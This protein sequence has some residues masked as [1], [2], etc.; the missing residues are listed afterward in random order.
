MNEIPKTLKYSQGIQNKQGY[1]VCFIG[2]IAC[3]KSTL[4]NELFNKN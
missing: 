3:G 1:H 4:I 2:P